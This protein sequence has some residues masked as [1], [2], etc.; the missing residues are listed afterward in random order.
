MLSH[1]SLWR[2]DSTLIYIYL[3][4]AHFTHHV[5]LSLILSLLSL[6]GF[7]SRLYSSI[8]IPIAL[9]LY[10]T[11]FLFFPL[12]LSSC[13]F[14]LLFI[15]PHLRLSLFPCL[16]LFPPLPASSTHPTPLSS[17]LQPATERCKNSQ[18]QIYPLGSS[19]KLRA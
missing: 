10:L 19:W 14:T 12:S 11:N 15:L 16:S 7:V 4:T 3:F 18:V 13:F 5:F 9:I 1:V 8:Y 6:L 17:T 2:L